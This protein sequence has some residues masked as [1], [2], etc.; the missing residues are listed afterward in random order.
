MVA[1]Q[2]LL[3]G[4]LAV[5]THYGRQF[6]LWPAYSASQGNVD[7]QDGLFD[8]HSRGRGA[9]TATTLAVSP[10]QSQRWRAVAAASIGNALEWFDFVVYGFLAVTMARL[11]F[12]TENETMSL[13]LALGT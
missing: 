6:P 3:P 11:F 9:M 8:G 4:G 10:G 1:R 13:L 12:P 5:I 2:F 7:E